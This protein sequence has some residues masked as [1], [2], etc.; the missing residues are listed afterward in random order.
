MLSAT[1]SADTVSAVGQQIQITA[2][3]APILYVITNNTG[4]IQEIISNNYLKNVPLT[5]FRNSDDIQNEVSTTRQLVT[6]YNGIMAHDDMHPGILY[7]HESVV[8]TAA[9][10]STVSPFDILSIAKL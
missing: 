10:R 6:Q 8:Q 9:K 7:S 5:V 3:V 2:S 1:A 4:T